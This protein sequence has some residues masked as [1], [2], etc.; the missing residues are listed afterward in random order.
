MPSQLSMTSIFIQFYL[1]WS[2]MLLGLI[3]DLKENQLIGSLPI[4]LGI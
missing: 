2:L 1:V 3:R 4:E